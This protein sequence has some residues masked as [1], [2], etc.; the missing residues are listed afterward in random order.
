M[1]LERMV[2]TL[3]LEPLPPWTNSFDPLAGLVK[4]VLSVS[5]KEDLEDGPGGKRG[6]TVGSC[7]EDMLDSDTV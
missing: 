5:S 7:T 4:P 2:G 3:F 6:L 1:L